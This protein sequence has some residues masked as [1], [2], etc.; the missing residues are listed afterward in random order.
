MIFIDRGNRVKAYE[1]LRNAGELIR[2][3]KSV[4]TFPEGSRSDDNTITM[5]KSGSFQLALEAE[6]PI[7]PVRLYSLQR[8]INVHFHHSA[9]PSNSILKIEAHHSD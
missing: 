7:I 1:S 5:F 2:S 9:E 6:V 3:G 8:I 4:I